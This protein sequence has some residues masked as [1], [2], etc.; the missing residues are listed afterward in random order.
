M[1]KRT[2]RKKAQPINVLEVIK[3]YQQQIVEAQKKNGVS[4]NQ[5]VAVKSFDSAV[6]F[7]QRLNQTVLVQN[8][9]SYTTGPEAPLDRLYNT[10]R[11]DSLKLLPAVLEVLGAEAAGIW[12]DL[13]LASSAYSAAEFYHRPEI[14]EETQKVY[15]DKTTLSTG[16][17]LAYAG[18]HGE[19]DQY[20]YGEDPQTDWIKDHAADIHRLVS[21]GDIEDVNRLTYEIA[22]DWQLTNVQLPPMPSD[23]EGDGDSDKQ[24]GDGSLSG[25]GKP[26]SKEDDSEDEDSESDSGGESTDEEGDGDSGGD[27]DSGDGHDGEDGDGSG[28]SQSD[29]DSPGSDGMGDSSGGRESSP[30]SSQ[31]PGEKGQQGQQGG[32][33]AEQKNPWLDKLHDAAQKLKR[34][35]PPPMQAAKPPQNTSTKARGSGTQKGHNWHVFEDPYISPVKIPTALRGILKEFMV[36]SYKLSDDTSGEV[37]DFAD[38]IRMGNLDIFHSEEKKSGRI[39]VMVDCSGSMQCFSSEGDRHYSKWPDPPMHNGGLAWLVAGV[40]SKA[41]PEAMVFGYTNTQGARANIADS[42]CVVNIPAGF[43]PTCV[44]CEKQALPRGQTKALGAVSGSN[45]MYMDGTPECTAYLYAESLLKGELEGAAC[46]VISDGDPNDVSH[47]KELAHKFYKDGLAFAVVEI[48]GDRTKNAKEMVRHFE[49]R[50]A[51]DVKQYGQVQNVTAQALQQAKDAM[52]MYPPALHT[53]I[54]DKTQL[55]RV[56][57]TLEFLRGRT[58]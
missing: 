35:E 50:A 52:D 20:P 58:E 53:Q 41:Y 37:S 46:V 21:S 26:E 56:A 12:A 36:P 24:E 33:P 39:I 57:K 54:S 13:Q 40:I 23:Q 3:S 5:S 19:L 8:D 16:E 15:A 18:L 45:F 1:A 17:K 11:A 51:A 34:I 31:R 2:R 47:T 42:T 6:T 22:R 48:G 38:E 10:H 4:V 30:Q 14:L 9:L 29:S 7:D 28:D 32:Q 49:M 27:S 44:H 55:H 25:K 43:R